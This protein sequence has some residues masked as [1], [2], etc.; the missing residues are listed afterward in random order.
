MERFQDISA[1]NEPG[2]EE[3][4]ARDMESEG[5]LPPEFMLGRP[6]IKN[7]SPI[8]ED[9]ERARHVGNQTYMGG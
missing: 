9:S 8:L 3:A 2:D 6:K 5:H 1:N 4:Q 7:D